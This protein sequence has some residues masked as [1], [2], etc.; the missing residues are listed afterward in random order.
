MLKIPERVRFMEN[1]E[2]FEIAKNFEINSK[3]TEISIIDSGH[4]N[5]TYLV[6]CENGEKYILQYVN[7]NVFPNI[8][9]LMN[10]IENVTDF[11]R[12]KGNCK[13]L[14]FIKTKSG[15]YIYNNNW[16]MQEFIENTKTFI[17]TESLDILKE[18]GKAI[19]NFQNELDGFNAESLYEIIPKFHYTPNRVNQLRDA[20]ES[21]TNK[22]QR[23]E[24]FEKANDCIKFLTEKNRIDKTKEITNRLENHI[25]PL[26]VTHNDTKLSNILMDKD[27]DTYVALIDLDTIMPGSVVYDF[28]EGIR[29]GVTVAPE[30]EQDLSKIHVDM[31]RF[32]AYTEG[33]LEM[34]GQS[35]TKEEK[36]LLPLGAWMMTYENAIRFLADY[37]NGDTYFSVDK[38]IQDHNL[39]R[40]KAQAEILRQMEENEE[41]MKGM[42]N[43]YGL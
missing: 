42:I 19:G 11:I 7:T 22:K 32:K 15:N 18:A 26:R 1:S 40:A 41:N 2:L 9:E 37:L 14:K 35:I 5:K 36:D 21:E 12:K 10:N 16:R 17:S 30:D 33:F 20:L 27:K 3:P 38:D 8:T 25:I 31:E 4:I 29:T 28:G 39:V 24:R 23:N 43:E 34:A 13:T 6:K